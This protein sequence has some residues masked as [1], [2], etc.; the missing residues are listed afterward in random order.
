MHNQFAGAETG[1]TQG[2]SGSARPL[3]V[4]V[5]FEGPDLWSQAGGLGVRVTNLSE[6]LAELGYE[7]HVFFLGDPSRPGEEVINGV[8]LHRWGQW[9]SRFHSAGVYDGEEAKLRDLT[10]SLPDYVTDRLLLPAIRAGRVSVVLMEE[11]QT[12]ECA[13]RIS[14]LLDAH[15]VRHRALLAWNANNA[16]SFERIDWPRLAVSTTITTVSRFMRAIIRARGIDALVIPNGIPHRLTLPVGR[17]AVNQVRSSFNGA[18]FFFKMARW[19]DDKGWSQ[20]LDAVRLMKSRRRRTMLVA[21]SGGPSS[22][23]SPLDDEARRRGLRVVAVDAP[24][25]LRRAAIESARRD[26][27]MLS[28]RFGVSESLARRMFAAADGILANSVAEPFGLVGLE[29]MA[30]GGLLYTGGTGEDYAVSGRNAVVL[31]TLN[32]AEIADRAEALMETPNEARRLRRAARNSARDFSWH[33]ITRRLLTKLQEQAK[34]QGLDLGLSA[35]KPTDHAA[36]SEEV[37]HRFADSMS[38]KAATCMP[39]SSANTPNIRVMP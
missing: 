19:G 10:L 7:V 33:H 29:A 8:V 6:T 15:G 17:A 37:S 30:A 12:S 2:S 26:V 24:E 32:P 36:A 31:E 3:F 14:D 11:W 16:Y 5:S 28:L 34:R 18:P 35:A 38:R 22:G 27:D 20:A 4:I 23:A 9:L 13:T 25:D 21:R 39:R 1:H